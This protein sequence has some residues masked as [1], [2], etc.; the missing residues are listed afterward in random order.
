MTNSSTK[1]KKFIQTGLFV[2]LIGWLT[3]LAVDFVGDYIALRQMSREEVAEYIQLKS[4]PQDVLYAEAREDEYG[5][6]V[7]KYA[8]M[9][10]SVPQTEGEDISRRTPNSH[11]YVLST[12]VKPT[13]ETIENVQ[14][15]FYASPQ[16]YEDNGNWR[17]IE[18]ATTTAE[19][20][21]KSGAIHFVKKREFLEWLLPGKPLFAATSTFYPDPNTETTSV[22]GRLTADG[23]VGAGGCSA[24]LA[25]AYADT[26]ASAVN[27]SSASE[28]LYLAGGGAYGSCSVGVQRIMTLFDTSALPD[29]AVVSA[30][31]LSLY[32]TGVSGAFTVNIQTTNPAANTSLTANDVDNFL[33]TVSSDASLTISTYNDFSLNPTGIAAISLTGVSKFGA[34]L[35]DDINSNTS[36]TLGQVHTISMAETSGTSQDPKLEVTY[37]T[38]SFSF[39]QWFPF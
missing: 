16:M 14:T 6:A 15:I 32:A 25:I 3:L 2:L 26:S 27:D 20:F 38:S 37:T 33:S 36:A 7:V 19:V 24:A 8:Y 5:Q 10:D 9:T 4:E 17:Q 28:Q 29:S 11:T 13:G 31:T 30:A 39:G 22:D 18:Y 12:E 23:S 35:V 34:R 1:L 21:S